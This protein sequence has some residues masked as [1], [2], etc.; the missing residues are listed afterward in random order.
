[1]LRCAEHLLGLLI[2]HVSDKPVQRLIAHA[3]LENIKIPSAIERKL[4][5]QLVCFWMLH[6]IELSPELIKEP[7]D[8]DIQ[9]LIYDILD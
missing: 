1:M 6:P 9:Q 5:C 3:F 4:H 2:N 8:S 7:H